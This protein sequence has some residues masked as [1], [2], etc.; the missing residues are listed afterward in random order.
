EYTAI[1]FGIMVLMTV[2]FGLLAPPVGLN[3]YVVNG[4]AKDVPMA[5][6]YRGVLPFLASDTIRTLLLLLFPGISLFILKYIG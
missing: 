3:V 4:M 5:E 6:S 2:G 1:W